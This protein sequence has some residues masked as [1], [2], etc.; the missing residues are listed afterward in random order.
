[1]SGPATCGS[2]QG[3]GGREQTAPGP[4]K[5]L[6][7]PSN[8]F[9]PEEILSSRLGRSHFPVHLGNFCCFCC[10]LNCI[11][12]TITTTSLTDF[13]SDSRTPCCAPGAHSTPFL[14]SS[15]CRRR[16]VFNSPSRHN[17]LLGAVHRLDQ[18]RRR[19]PEGRCQRP[20]PAQRCRSLLPIRPRRCHL[21]LRNTRCSYPR[22][23]VRRS[24]VVPLVPCRA[25]ELASCPIAR[26]VLQSTSVRPSVRPAQSG[27]TNCLSPP[28][29]CR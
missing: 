1:M 8:P 24:L 28:C 6:W 11:P 12:C 23:C 10:P 21:L 20:W 9:R 19:R 15:P 3:C 17:E 16:L 14:F 13:T 22:R 5:P 29:Q 7:A 25:L 18:G 26:L 4:V 2:R 27:R